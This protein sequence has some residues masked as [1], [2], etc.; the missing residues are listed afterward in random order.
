M[1]TTTQ[2]DAH[3]AE[4]L[5]SPK[6]GRPDPA[7]L[8]EKYALAGMFILLCVVFA[9][10]SSTAETFPTVANIKNVLGGESVIAIAALAS[11]LPL[12]CGQFDLSVGAVIG[13]SSIVGAS[14]VA[15][16]DLPVAVAVL[17]GVLAGSLVGAFNGWLVAYRGVNALIATLGTSTLV[18]GLV[19]LYTDNQIISVGIPESLTNLGA[20]DLLGIPRPVYAIAIVALFVYYLLR[21]TPYGRYLA[22]VGASPSS[23]RLVGLNV[24]R[25]IL[26]SFVLSG[27]LSGIAGILLLARAGTANPQ[28]GPGF[29]LAALSAAFLGATAIRPGTFNVPGTLLGVL[30]VAISVNG[31]VLAG[32]ADWVEPT[33]N[34]VALLVAVTLSTAI[35][36]RRAGQT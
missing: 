10:M 29:T 26:S 1:T 14:A 19:S 36:R 21:H 31:L 18:A 3:H 11:I 25:M 32:T 8:L 20:G 5:V 16:H 4:P 23:A 12:T 6:R 7:V 17:A 13:L 27:A 24:P 28:V 34:G 35:A 2:P 22:S 30:F 33:F 9:N 15:T